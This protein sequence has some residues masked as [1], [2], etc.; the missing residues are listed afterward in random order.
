MPEVEFFDKNK[1]NEW[2][3]RQFETYRFNGLSLSDKFIP[4][5]Y[6]SLLFHFKECPYIVQEPPLKLEL[7][8]VAP[9]IPRAISLK[10]HGVMDTLTVTCKATVFS[11]LFNLDLS[12]VSK[13][14]INLPQQIFLRLWETMAHLKTPIWTNQLLFRFLKFSTENTLSTECS[15]CTLRQNNRKGY[16]NSAEKDYG[17][18]L[19]KQKYPATEI[20]QTHWGKSQNTGSYRPAGLFVDE[21]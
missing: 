14:S 9:I 13:R 15:R 2:L 18:V 6:I 5:P 17:G 16:H 21:N 11:N 20:R 7:F 12:P 3:I 1:N 19:C 8:F 10:F 4:C